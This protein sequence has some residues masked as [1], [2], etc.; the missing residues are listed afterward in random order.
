MK[1]QT[2]NTFVFVITNGEERLSK[3]DEYITSDNIHWVKEK[4]I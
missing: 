3:N 2:Q 1:P 4:Y